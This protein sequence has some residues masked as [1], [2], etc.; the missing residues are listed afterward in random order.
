MELTY[1]RV[2]KL[3]FDVQEVVERRILMEEWVDIE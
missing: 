1:E 2:V 3:E